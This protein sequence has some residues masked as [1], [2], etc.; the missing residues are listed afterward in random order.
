MSRDL[1]DEAIKKFVIGHRPL[2]DNFSDPVVFKKK[3]EEWL[4]DRDAVLAQRASWVEKEQIAEVAR[5]AEVARVAATKQKQKRE[6]A[7][8]KQLQ[9]ARRRASASAD[10]IASGVKA[11]AR[12]LSKGSSVC[13]LQN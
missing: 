6:A 3:D 1:Q 7:E 2:I 13:F 12:C 10:I 9:A 5:S 11:C 8:Q 4:E